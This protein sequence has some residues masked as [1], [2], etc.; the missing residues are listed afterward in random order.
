M[1]RSPRP[2]TE[3]TGIEHTSRRR[4]FR[5]LRDIGSILQ[6]SPGSG[7]IFRGTVGASGG[8]REAPSA[9]LRSEDGDE[10]QQP[11]GQDIV[12]RA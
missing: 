1:Q 10:G 12:A 3:G 6:D 8:P 7:M 5:L 9:Q 2:E 4:L 11:D